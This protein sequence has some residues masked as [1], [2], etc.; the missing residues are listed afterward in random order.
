M[1]YQNLLTKIAAQCLLPV[2]PTVQVSRIQKVMC[3]DNL[4][5]RVQMSMSDAVLTIQISG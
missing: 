2:L 4:V 3:R 1:M 5:F